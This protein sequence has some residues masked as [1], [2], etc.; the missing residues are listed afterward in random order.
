MT[1]NSILSEKDFK[2]IVRN[3]IKG[4]KTFTVKIT[5]DKNIY[6]YS[7]A[8]ILL[9]RSVKGR[10]TEK[11]VPEMPQG[12]SIFG[13]NISFHQGLAV[14]TQVKNSVRSYLAKNPDI[15][16][17]KSDRST[18]NKNQVAYAKIEQGSMFYSVDINH[19]YF[20]V[21]HKLGYIDDILYETY[22]DQDEY[23]KAFHFSCS[24]LAARAKIYKYRKGLLKQIIDTSETD[25]ELKIVYSNVRHTL[26]NLLGE[27]YDQ[28]GN[29]AIAYIT[30]E[31]LIHRDALPAVK[32]YFKRQ[33][34][35]FKITFCKKS[36]NTEYIKANSKT[37][38]IFGKNSEKQL[39]LKDTQPIANES[40]VSRTEEFRKILRR[41]Q[42]AQI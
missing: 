36:T 39:E 40:H 14:V 38:K 30:D 32:E 2:Q 27:I 13:S 28:L 17:I 1:S 6:L 11:K 25:K 9:A 23:K 33:G 19:A 29:S 21:L 8:E 37:Y 34:Y 22:K 41:R 18:V 7:D 4:K 35:E 5:R 26:Q 15:T 12:S 42:A 10:Q 3:M 31:I 16:E 24:W 20:Q